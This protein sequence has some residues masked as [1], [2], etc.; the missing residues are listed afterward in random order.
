MY[1]RGEK[2]G[3][4]CYRLLCRSGQIIYL[5]TVGLLEI[6]SSGTVESFICINTLVDEK[7]GEKLIKEMKQK[8][9]P[10]IEPASCSDVS[11]CI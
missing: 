6:D 8:Y 10:L 4:S 3:T 9:S 11:T 1:D 7:E 2:K 5:R